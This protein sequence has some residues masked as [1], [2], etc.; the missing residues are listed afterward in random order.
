MHKMSKVEEGNFHSRKRRRK[1]KRQPGKSF[2]I[3]L[4]N[5]AICMKYAGAV[6]KNGK[7]TISPCIDTDYNTTGIPGV[8]N[9]LGEC[10]NTYSDNY[11]E[12][13]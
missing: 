8:I 11:Q 13:D 10:S 3:A 4:V 9:A 1:E 7:T 12:L 5:C 6:E 2:A